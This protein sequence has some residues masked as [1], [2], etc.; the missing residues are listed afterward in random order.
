MTL[1]CTWVKNQAGALVMTWTADE[2][3][4]PQPRDA[5]APHK[6]PRTRPHQPSAAALIPGAMLPA[7]HMPEPAAA[8]TVPAAG[9]Q[10]TPPACLQAGALSLETAR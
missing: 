9:A 10:A 5:T 2:A 8:N 6:N 7:W 3:P 1:T 4:L